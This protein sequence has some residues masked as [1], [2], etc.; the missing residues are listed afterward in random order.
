MFEK[1]S[2]LLVCVIIA[3]TLLSL[4]DGWKLRDLSQKNDE[5]KV[6]P[7]K[8]FFRDMPMK[9]VVKVEGIKV[10]SGE[11]KLSSEDDEATVSDDDEDFTFEKVHTT[12]FD[13]PLKPVVTLNNPDVEQEEEERREE[14][15]DTEKVASWLSHL[16]SFH[17]FSDKVEDERSQQVEHESSGYFSWFT[18]AISELKGDSTEDDS[19]D[20]DGIDWFSYVKSL[21]FIS[22]LTELLYSNDDSKADNVI[23][24]RDNSDDLI[25]EKREPLTTQSFENLLLTIPSF[26][27]NYT[28]IN[29]VDCRRMGQIFQRQVRG[30]KLW[31]LQSIH[32]HSRSH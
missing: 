16:P 29:D 1:R 20:D 27:P 19:K 3:V 26:I 12:H 24:H 10:N 18:T 30:Q 25:T 22:E 2:F 14:A 9:K 31:A 23:K 28:K 8:P 32:S 21:S 11:S 15:V 17:F 13:L 6:S 7:K 4:V 5:N